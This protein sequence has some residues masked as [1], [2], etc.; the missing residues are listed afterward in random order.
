MRLKLILFLENKTLLV[1]TLICAI[2]R[3]IKEKGYISEQY[4]PTLDSL[5]D[6][7]CSYSYQ[8]PF[9][10]KLRYLKFDNNI[11]DS[12]LNLHTEDNKP[13]CISSNNLNSIDISSNLLFQRSLDT[14]ANMTGFYN[15]TDLKLQD[16][17][18]PI[19]RPSVFKQFRNVKKLS[20]GYNHLEIPE[21]YKICTGLPQLQ[22]LEMSNARLHRIPPY[23]LENC[24]ELADM[25]LSQ[26]RLTS[27]PSTIRNLLDTLADDH[28]SRVNLSDN[29][30]S[31]QCHEEAKGTISWIHTTKVKL[32]DRN[33]YKCFGHKGAEFVIEKNLQE[34][35]DYCKESNTVIKIS[36]MM[37]S[38][39][40]GCFAFCFIGSDYKEV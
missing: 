23:F 15:V 9:A 5:R 38:I 14:I 37:T 32:L 40:C 27:L 6:P 17:N 4:I 39:G 34:Y 25:D 16:L 35:L 24:K 3:G 8:L 36:L 2:S 26:N 28:E 19:F 31:C 29:V 20:V 12:P 11:N 30:F 22:F 21:D 13:F 1:E 7:S 10:P 33:T 18:L